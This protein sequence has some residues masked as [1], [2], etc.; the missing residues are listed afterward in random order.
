MNSNTRREYLILTFIAIYNHI[1][2]NRP[3]S[4]LL[5]KAIF[6]IDSSYHYVLVP[7]NRARICRA[8]SCLRGDGEV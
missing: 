2:Y 1:I 4:H 7:R 5:W 6:T 3:G 8:D